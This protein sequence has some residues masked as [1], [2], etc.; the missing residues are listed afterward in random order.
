[1][2]HLNHSAFHPDYGFP[3]EF[4]LRVLRVAKQTSV[5]KAAE[6]FGVSTQA[7]YNWRQ[8]YQIQEIVT[9]ATPVKTSA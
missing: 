3:D 2:T 7:V 8:A 9:P 5:A 1:M 6:L 4:R